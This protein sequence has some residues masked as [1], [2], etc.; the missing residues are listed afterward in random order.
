MKEQ[1]KWNR[2]DLL[3]NSVIHRGRAL[4]NYE[5]EVQESLDKP[6]TFEAVNKPNVRPFN[7]VSKPEIRDTLPK[8]DPTMFNLSQKKSSTMKLYSWKTDQ[9]ELMVIKNKWDFL[10]ESR[11]KRRNIKRKERNAKSRRK[12]TENK[13]KLPNVT[14]DDQF[15]CPSSFNKTEVHRCVRSFSSPLQCKLFF[16]SHKHLHWQQ[17]MGTCCLKFHVLQTKQSCL[18]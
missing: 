8:G 7:P 17:H 14:I 3:H 4:L 18:N 2:A 10:S 1:W 9:R 16:L 15:Y 11:Q 5:G 12:A 6:L 13:S